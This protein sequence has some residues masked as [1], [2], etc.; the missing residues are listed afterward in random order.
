MVYAIDSNVKT[1]IE[2]LQLVQSQR[3]RF[4]LYKETSSDKRF[5]KIYNNKIENIKLRFK[6][7]FYTNL[8][9]IVLKDEIQSSLEQSLMK[10]K[11]RNDSL[12]FAVE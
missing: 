9:D 1:V 10:V 2:K 6:K 8:K 7:I 4:M 3:F 5:A 11:V 12:L